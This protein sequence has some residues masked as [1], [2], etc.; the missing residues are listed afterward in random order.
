MQHVQHYCF[1]PHNRILR[2]IF[3]PR[4]STQRTTG[5][6][7]F[8]AL[9]DA[10]TTLCSPQFAP[11]VARDCCTAV[12]LLTRQRRERDRHWAALPCRLRLASS[13]PNV[14]LSFFPCIPRSSSSIFFARPL[15]LSDSISVTLGPQWA[16]P[17]PP[18]A[19]PRTRGPRP[20]TTVLRLT[21]SSRTQMHILSPNLHRRVCSR[22]EV[23]M[24][25]PRC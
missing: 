8:G 14:V 15:S 22:R 19:T 23:Q 11:S 20:P 10:I 9:V 7:R 24:S 6:T 4:S 3:Q 2:S 16:H 1:S 5:E 17:R 12:L 18:T 13:P 25:T 21:L